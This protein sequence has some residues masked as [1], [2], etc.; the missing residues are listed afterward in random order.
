VSEPLTDGLALHAIDLIIENL[1]EAVEHGNNLKSRENMLAA[2]LMA[3]IAFGNAD[4]AG[5]HCMAESLGGLYDTPHGI[6]NSIFLPY[7]YEYN[8]PSD[9]KKHAIVARR[10]GAKK[11]R[12]DEETAYKGVESLKKLAADV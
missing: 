7:V 6:A 11:G 2:S 10:L 4:V 3:G 1:Q 12:N 5:V 9:V 8:I